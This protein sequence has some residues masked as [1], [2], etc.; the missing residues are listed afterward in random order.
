[1]NFMAL[2]KNSGDEKKI[3]LKTLFRG[4]GKN[5]I[6]CAKKNFTS[7]L[8]H[9]VLSFS[10]NEV[11]SVHVFQSHDSMNHW[12]LESYILIYE[13]YNIWFISIHMNHLYS[14][15]HHMIH[16]FITQLHYRN[17]HA[18]FCC[19]EFNIWIQKWLFIYKGII[20]GLVFSSAK[21]F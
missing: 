8:F 15:D 12:F 20:I 6:S 2:E 10:V 9:P 21:P 17:M 13:S 7:W 3:Q 14:Y 18:K 11:T 16:I 4:R 19:L 5:L 1:M